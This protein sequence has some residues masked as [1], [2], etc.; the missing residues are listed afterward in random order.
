MFRIAHSGAIVGDFLQR[1]LI[2]MKILKFIIRLM[3]DVLQLNQ[4]EGTSAGSAE[5]KFDLALPFPLALGDG[6]AYAI[7]VPEG[8]VTV[9]P[10]KVRQE[11][12]DPRLFV[13]QTTTE[14]ARDRYGWLSYTRLEIRLDVSAFSGLAHNLRVPA[15]LDSSAPMV[16]SELSARYVIRST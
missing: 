3:K 14:L 5:Y 16:L 13:E 6:E 12:P 2:L 11:N 1:L 9:T 7:D 10:F 15:A 8:T 4:T